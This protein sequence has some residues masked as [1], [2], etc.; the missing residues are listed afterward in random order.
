MFYKGLMEVTSLW[1][2]GLWTGSCSLQRAY[3][4]IS[5]G[6]QKLNNVCT[7]YQR[8]FVKFERGVPEV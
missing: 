5:K 2:C 4:G 1:S 8:S 3:R 7:A 6:I